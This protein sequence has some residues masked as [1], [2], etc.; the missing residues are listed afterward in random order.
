MSVPTVGD[1]E[2]NICVY[3]CIWLSCK[4]NKVGLRQG[5]LYKPGREGVS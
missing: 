4:S 5:N 3:I 2:V 1:A